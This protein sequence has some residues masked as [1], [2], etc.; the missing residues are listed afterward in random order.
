MRALVNRPRLLLADE[1]TGSL[2]ERGADRLG[3]LLVE[4]NSEHDVALFVVTHSRRL[5]DRMSRAIE[6]RDGVLAGAAAPAGQP[7]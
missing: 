7:R 3:E 6:L 1:P 2:D 5:A 4:L